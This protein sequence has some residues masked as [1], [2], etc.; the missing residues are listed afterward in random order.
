MIFEKRGDRAAGFVMLLHAQ[1]Q[2]LGAAQHQPRVE[3]RENRAGAVL[4]EG[5][6]VRIFFVV[7]HHRASHA[8]RMPVQEFCS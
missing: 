5:N 7:Q 6:P 3:G 1:R 2:G 4:D 8:I